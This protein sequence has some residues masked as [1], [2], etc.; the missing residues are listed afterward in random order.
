[1]MA[2]PDISVVAEILWPHGL[3]LRGSFQ[4]DHEDGA[5]KGTACLVLVGN[6]GGA[7]WGAFQKERREEPHPLDN[8]SRRVVGGIAERLGARALFPFEGPPWLPFQRW[9]MKA[10]GLHPSPI[11]PLIHPVYGPWH[12]YRGALAFDALLEG[13]PKP[14]PPGRNICAECA[15]KPCLSS[16]PANVFAKGGYD[17]PRCVGHLRQ[18]D[19]DCLPGGCLAR[20]ACPVGRDHAYG[21]EQ[22]GFHTGAF[23]AGMDS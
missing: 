13:L 21:R 10:E 16:C 8:W 17:V 20:R 23:L 7:M 9:A 4:P 19:N 12:G 18:A 3:A 22:A 11:G 2:A 1:M 14:V 15:L 5:P 6:L